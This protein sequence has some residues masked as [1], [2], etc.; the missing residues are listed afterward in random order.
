MITPDDLALTLQVVRMGAMVDKKISWRNMIDYAYDYREEFMDV[1]LS[2]MCQFFVS[3]PSGI[4]A[5]PQLFSKPLISINATILT[6]RNDFLLLTH[7]ERD[8][9]IF[10]KFWWKSKLRYLTFSEMLKREVDEKY[11]EFAAA[12]TFAA[13]DA[14]GIIPVE[15][16][17][18]EINDVVQ[19]MVAKLNGTMVYTEEDERLQQKYFDLIDTYPM[20]NNFPFMWRVGAKFLRDNAWLLE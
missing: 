10:K 8:L 6:T 18:E 7:R 17:P 12:G 13:Y 15:N 3:N 20:K 19:E 4:Q 14:E 5:L 11:H 9:V 1:F 16:T 2:S